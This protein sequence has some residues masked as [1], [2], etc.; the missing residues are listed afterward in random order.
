MERSGTI[1]PYLGL[2]K[3]L[4]KM[5][6]DEK[7]NKMSFFSHFDRHL[8][9][10]LIL[11]LPFCVTMTLLIL[12][13][14]SLPDQLSWGSVFNDCNGQSQSPI[15]INTN[16]AIYDA[17]LPSIKLAGYDLTDNTALT[18]LNNGHTR[19]KKAQDYVTT[20]LVQM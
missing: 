2:E 16:A 4:H 12:S 19:K 10:H 20:E 3:G 13:L 6:Y 9:F 7:K 1:T 11:I 18:L 5:I 17:Q 8:L 15:D 14:R